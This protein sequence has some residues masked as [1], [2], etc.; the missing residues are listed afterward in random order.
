MVEIQITYL[1]GL[2]NQAVHAPSGTTLL[3]DAPVDNHGK[4]EAFSPT[5]LLG[6]ALGCCMSTMMGIVAERHGWDLKGLSVRVI[7]HMT[8][9]GPRKIRLLEVEIHIPLSEKD[10]PS[11]MLKN[12]AMTCPV[13]HSLD[14]AIE[15]K[16]TFYWAKN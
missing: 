1:G 6:A 11:G 4:G 16:I 14:P 5:D 13:H 8:T 15:Q 2:R 12:A 3:T 9:Q 7:K 10:D